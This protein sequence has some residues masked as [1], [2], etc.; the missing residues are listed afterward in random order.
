M[1][2]IRQR[3]V[4]R[5]NVSHEFQ[6]VCAEIIIAAIDADIPRRTAIKSGVIPCHISIDTHHNHGM[7]RDERRDLRN[8]IRTLVVMFERVPVTVSM[9][10]VDD[11]V[12]RARCRVISRQKEPVVSILTKHRGFMQR[13]CGARPHDHQR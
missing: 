13:L 9:E 12:S 11:R 2:A 3:A 4:R 10:V 1:S 5:V 6:E 8:S 7:F